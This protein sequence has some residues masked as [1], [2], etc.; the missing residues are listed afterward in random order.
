MGTHVTV[1]DNARISRLNGTHLAESVDTSISLWSRF[2]VDK[3]RT[4]RVSLAT[5]VAVTT[6]VSSQHREPFPR[7]RAVTLVGGATLDYGTS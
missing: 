6:V 5:E 2:S 1:R 4:T 7:N 3:H